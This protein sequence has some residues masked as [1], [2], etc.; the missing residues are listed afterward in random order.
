MCW[1]HE[2]NIFCR[3]AAACNFGDSSNDGVFIVAAF[4]DMMVNMFMNMV[5]FVVMDMV[6]F[7]LM[8]MV[9]LV[10]VEML[11]LMNMMFS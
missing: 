5:V 4:M 9:M 6:V 10:S 2:S 8:N 7:V 1:H 11:M 3:C